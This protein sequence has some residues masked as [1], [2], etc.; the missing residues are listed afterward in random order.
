MDASPPEF[1][2]GMQRAQ[3]P[4][5]HLCVLMWRYL[6]LPLSSLGRASSPPLIFYLLDSMCSLREWG[7]VSTVAPDDVQPARRIGRPGAGRRGFAGI[8]L[9]GAGCAA[10]AVGTGGAGAAPGVP[11]HLGCACWGCSRP[12]GCGAAEVAMVRAGW[13]RGPKDGL[14]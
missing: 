5:S 9:R 11:G 7:G 14:G 2:G 10:P 3:A 4:C 1:P 6:Q 8:R 13:C 12:G